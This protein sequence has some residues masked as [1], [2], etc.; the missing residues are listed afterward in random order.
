M[1]HRYWNPAHDEA[2]NMDRFGPQTQVH[3]HN[4]TL[5]AELEGQIDD[6]TGIV[7]NLVDVKRWL[8]DVVAPF[9]NRYVAPASPLLAGRQPSTECLA[10]VLWERL[11]DR[12]VGTPATLIAVKVLESDT[13]R[14]EF[15][16]EGTLVYVTR[17]YDFSASHRLH[18]RRLTDEANLRVFGKC[19]NRNGHGHNYVLEVTVRGE[20]DPDTGFAYPIDRLDAIVERRVISVLDHRDLNS[21]VPHFAAVNP[22]SENLAVFIWQAISPD[23]GPAL[24]CV[25]LEET[26]R[27]AFEYRG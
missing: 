8:D 19:N 17:T 22:T 27:N 1:A 11:R 25:R 2:W 12:A 3:G 14:S 21:D 16:G 13:L 9:D 18:S 5:V 26:P 20:I 4:Y 7:V 23:V 6:D 24:H 15:R 10:A